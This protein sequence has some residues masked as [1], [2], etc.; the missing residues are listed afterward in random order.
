[1]VPMAVALAFVDFSDATVTVLRMAREVAGALGMKLI[2]M[3]V[4]TPDAEMEG[5]RQRTNLSRGAIAREMHHYHRE[6]KILALECNKLGVD[7]SA[8]LVRGGSIRG[9]PVSKMISEL[10][11]VKPALIIMGTHQHGRLFEAVLGSASTK[12]VHKAPCPIL[13]IPS[14]N[15]S[16]TWSRNK[17]SATRPSAGDDAAG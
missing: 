2:L 12:V 3:H 10:K 14:Q 5:Q 7:T 4:S 8:L 11:R 16:L 13:L 1:M 17:K 9:D 15:R 6:L